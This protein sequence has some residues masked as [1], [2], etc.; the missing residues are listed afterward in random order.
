MHKLVVGPWISPPPPHDAWVEC[1]LQR[2][3]LLASRHFPMPFPGTLAPLP[4]RLPHHQVPL[5]PRSGLQG[6]GG[7]RGDG[8]QQQPAPGVALLRHK[9]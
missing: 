6:V 4:R 9:P 2:R 8:A 5:L 3:R 1:C 7:L